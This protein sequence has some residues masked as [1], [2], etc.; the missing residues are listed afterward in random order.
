VVDSYVTSLGDLRRTSHPGLPWLTLI[1]LPDTDSVEVDHRLQVEALL[2]KVDFVVWVSDVEKYR[3]HVL[4]RNF[5]AP[6]RA[7]QGQFLFVLNQVD[8]VPKA[9]VADLVR[10]FK[11]ALIDDGIDE[12]EVVSV[13]ANP[14]LTPPYN[15]DELRD[16][17]ERAATGSVLWKILSDLEVA[18]ESLGNAG[19]SGSLDFDNRWNSTRDEAARDV[20]GGDLI[21]PSRRLAAFFSGLA[22]ELWGKAAEAALELS[23]HMG[24]DVRAIVQSLS[25]D[26]SIVSKSSRRRWWRSL[27]H[28]NAEARSPGSVDPATVARELDGLISSRL[29]PLLR[30]RAVVV[31]NLASLSVA[32]AESRASYLR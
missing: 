22:D 29:R 15:I 10:D 6:L 23:A 32:V 18:V 4:H 24:E 14:P 12:P 13:A 9:E 25:S 20:A 19:A 8:R 7:Y 26:P 1:D 27:G 31:A 11:S 28:G 16:R 3:D 21:G 30:Q 5:I 2:P 17:L